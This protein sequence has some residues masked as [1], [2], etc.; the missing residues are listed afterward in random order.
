[1]EFSPKNLHFPLKRTGERQNICGTAIVSPN[2]RA[3]LVSK[4]PE[5]LALGN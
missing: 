4:F 1:M 5:V 2:R 3:P